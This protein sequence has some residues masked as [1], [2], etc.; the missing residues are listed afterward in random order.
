MCIRD[1]HLTAA[2]LRRSGERWRAMFEGMQEAFFLSEA[3]RDAQGRT[4][5][6]RFIEVHPAFERQSGMKAGDT[7]GHTLR[8]IC[9]L[10]T[11]RGV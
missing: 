8:E 1:R 6:F 2:A 5:D 11:S 9:L 3:L 10:Y 4:V 7:L